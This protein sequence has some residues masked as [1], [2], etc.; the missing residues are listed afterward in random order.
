MG[1]LVL[2]DKIV[3]SSV[4]AECRHCLDHP[5]KADIV[6]LERVGM[7]TEVRRPRRR[8]RWGFVQTGMIIRTGKAGLRRNACF[9]LFVGQ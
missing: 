2:P 9:R 5:A 7:R 4:V 8:I 1:L 3:H 6:S